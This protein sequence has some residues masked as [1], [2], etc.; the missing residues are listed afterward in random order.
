MSTIRKDKFGTPYLHLPL[1]IAKGEVEGI[2]VEN[3]ICESEKIGTEY[4]KV[5]SQ[6]K[7]SVYLET[8]DF[9]T[10]QCES[11][12][13]QEG[14]DGARTVLIRGLD[15]NFQL[16]KDE[17]YLG[18]KETKTNIKFFRVFTFQILKT[19]KLNTNAGKI[20]LNYDKSNCILSIPEGEGREVFGGYTV[21]LGHNAYIRKIQLFADSENQNDFY[22][23]LRKKDQG[24]V[25]HCHLQF[26]SSPSALVFDSPIQISELTDIEFRAKTNKGTFGLSVFAEITVIKHSF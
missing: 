5:C 16:A 18:K 1:N 23:A 25:K 2:Y 12:K 14:K 9:L 6:G 26:K 3:I 19:G 7:N 10:V 24:F 8:A 20:S 15:S 22:I 13:D 21:P 11:I 17:V 4:E